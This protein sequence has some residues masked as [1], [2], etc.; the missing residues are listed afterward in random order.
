MIDASNITNYKQS[1]EQLEM[2]LLFWV[3]AAGKNGTRAANITNKLVKKICSD[4]YTPFFSLAMLPQESI[5]HMLKE[6]GSGCHNIKGRTIY[7][8]THAGLN[9]RT[10]GPQ[11]LEKIHGIGKKTSRCFILHSRKNAKAAGLDTHILKFLDIIGVPNVP[12]STP[13][14]NKE[15]LRLEQEFLK[16]CDHY[17]MKPA[18][19]DLRVWNEYSVGN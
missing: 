3:L 18:E 9:L 6:L 19:L 2:S 16:A 7:E 4:G 14:S 1:N 12:K 13:S 15:Y 5:A 11:D 17:K 8:L 10:C